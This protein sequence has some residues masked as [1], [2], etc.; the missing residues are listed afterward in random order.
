MVGSSTTGEVGDDR[1]GR[2]CRPGGRGERLADDRRRAARRNCGSVVQAG[3]ATERYRTGVTGVGDSLLATA[4][5]CTTQMNDEDLIQAE[6]VGC[7]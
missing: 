4:R 2:R 6:I 5:A 1:P 7:L 3:G